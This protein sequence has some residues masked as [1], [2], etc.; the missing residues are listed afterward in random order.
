MTLVYCRG[1][2]RAPGLSGRMGAPASVALVGTWVWPRIP[3]SSE[4][5][6]QREHGEAV[7]RSGQSQASWVLATETK[8]GAFHGLA[9]VQGEDVTFRPGEVAGPFPRVT[10]DSIASRVLEHFTSPMTSTVLL[11]P[12]AFAHRFLLLPAYARNS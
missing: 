3:G 6:P 1:K 9:A 2:Y 5:C 4:L 8:M 10:G 11:R 12:L 7:T